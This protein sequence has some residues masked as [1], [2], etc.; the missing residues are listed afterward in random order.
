M[1]NREYFWY[2]GVDSRTLGIWLEEPIS[3]PGATPR[4]ENVSIPGRNGDL[5]IY[6]GSYDNVNVSIKCVVVDRDG[7]TAAQA[8]ERIKGWTV[9]HTGYRQLVLPN[10]DGFHMAMIQTGPGR[11]AKAQKVRQFT[12]TLNCKPQVFTFEGQPAVE[13]QNGAE[14]YNN[15]MEALPKITVYGQGAG[16]LSI[17][18]TVI[19]LHEIDGYVE[20][21]CE[22]KDATKGLENKN[23]SIYAPEFPSLAPGANRISYTG[24]VDRVE[25]VPRWWHL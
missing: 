11:D 23:S 8:L 12:L 20:L 10:E 7:M 1:D 4:V 18:G 2:D 16:T 22:T 13:V 6:D 5:I 14:L 17:N 25:I 15:G 24:G 21:D 19:T 9:A 3:I